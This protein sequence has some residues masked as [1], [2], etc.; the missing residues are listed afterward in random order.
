M[1]FSKKISII[2]L[3]L[4]TLIILSACSSVN[5]TG[6]EAHKK[7]YT[8]RV[9][10]NS[11]EDHPYQDGLVAFKQ[12][13][14]QESKGRIK[15]E[16]Y[17]N[18]ELYSSER[19][20]VEAVQLNNIAMTVSS[21]P[22]MA[23]FEPKLDV[24][25]LPFLFD[26][27][28]AAHRALDGDLGKTLNKS[29]SKLNLINLGYGDNGFRHIFNTEKPIKSP[30]DLSDLNFRVLENGMYENMFNEMGANASPLGFGEL[31]SAVQ[32]GVYN[33]ADSEI[34]TGYAGNFDE[35]MEYGTL[36]EHTFMPAMLVINKNVLESLPPDLQNIIKKQGKKAWQK[37]QREAVSN[38]QDKMLEKLSKDIELTELTSEQKEEFKEKL[39]PLTKKYTNIIGED[40][41]EM[42]K[43]GNEKQ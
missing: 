26:S 23:S 1:N 30:S 36:S 38:K 29:L 11:S 6:E 37:Q 31:Y 22:S 19:E 43:K 41:V 24:F 39:K 27:R 8:F 17:P 13:V 34:T 15:V 21:T 4:I 14:E 16:I 20:A 28:D 3:L 2:S 18:G 40:L 32:Q 10:H 9:S 12:G 5:V 7:T 42:A 25:N 33:G 35:I